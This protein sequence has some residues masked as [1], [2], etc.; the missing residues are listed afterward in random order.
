MDKDWIPTK[1]HLKKFCDRTTNGH[2]LLNGSYGNNVCMHWNHKNYSLEKKSFKEKN[3]TRFHFKKKDRNVKQLALLWFSDNKSDIE[4]D[5]CDTFSDI[6]S[7]NGSIQ[8]EYDENEFII[9]TEKIKNE[10]N[11]YR[12]VN[13]CGQR[14]CV[15]PLHIDIVKKRNKK[16]Q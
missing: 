16:V 1:T 5:Y 7:I 8:S 4:E 6:S 3:Y 11:E 2:L 9:I 10:K 14:V 12:F 15:N 13:S